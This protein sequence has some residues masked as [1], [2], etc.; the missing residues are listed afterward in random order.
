M[1]KPIYDE[2]LIKPV[3]NAIFERA[4]LSPDIEMMHWYM[5]LDE[6]FENDE[7]HPSELSNVQWRLWVLLEKEEPLGF[8][9]HM[10]ERVLL[11]AGCLIKQNDGSLIQNPP[12]KEQ[13]K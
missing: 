5:W 13:Q 9:P 8:L 10:I 4:K 11:K 7:F 2:S 6:C 3:R 1:T 12:L